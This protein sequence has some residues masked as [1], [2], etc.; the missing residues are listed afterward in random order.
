MSHPGDDVLNRPGVTKTVKRV[1]R[2]D[3]CSN[4]R[5]RSIYAQSAW[6]YAVS[7]LFTHVILVYLAFKVLTNPHEKG[8]RDEP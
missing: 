7:S 3:G 5:G 6:K 2:G 1:Q 4:R 8:D